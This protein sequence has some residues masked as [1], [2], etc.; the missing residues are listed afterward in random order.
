MKTIAE[1]GDLTQYPTLY[2]QGLTLMLLSEWL[3]S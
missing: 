2:G 1:Y 3:S